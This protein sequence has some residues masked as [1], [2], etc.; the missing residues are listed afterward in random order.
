MKNKLIIHPFLF[1]IFPVLSLFARNLEEVPL[2]TIYLPLFFML[3]FGGV[4]LAA[5]RFIL[6]DIN[7]AGI[8]TSVFIIL[9]FSYGHVLSFV[10]VYLSGMHAHLQHLMLL[11]TWCVVLSLILFFV[12]RTKASLQKYTSFLNLVARV[13]IVLVLFNIMVGWLGLTPG[14]SRIERKI[15]ATVNMKSD[16]VPNIYYII[17]DRYASASTL[18]EAYHYDNS[19]FI[20]SLKRRGFY[21]A[22]QSV[23]NYQITWLSLA[24]SLNLV[25]FDEE[26]GIDKVSGLK[27]LE[28]HKVGQ[29]LKA[30]GYKFIHIGSG[31]NPLSHNRNADVNINYY[32]P[33]EFTMHIYENSMFYPVFSV[34]FEFDRRAQKHKRVLYKFDKFADL[35]QQQG[36][37]FVFAHF[38]L[39]HQP[40]SFD[41]DGN[42]IDRATEVSWGREK[43]YREQLIYTNGMIEKMVDD[44]LAGSKQPPIIVIQADEGP[45][46]LSQPL[47]DYDWNKMSDLELAQKMRILNAY[48]LPGFD[49]D[50]LYPSVSPVNSFR[51]IFNYY[52]GQNY[53]ILSDRS[54]LRKNGRFIDVTTKVKFN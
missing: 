26:K 50:E 28:D 9:A 31:W 7:K 54:Y 3:S 11:L 19:H 13:L 48:Y 21:V 20:D 51:F 4:V 43:A 46:S 23:A 27:M 45:Y 41:K 14:T 1:A 30:N 29:F 38:Q 8:V 15:E 2:V 47:D 32:F 53:K 34:L 39:P 18:K 52:F 10:K 49:D 44:I 24:S 22:H 33:D 42:F 16:G 40:Y 5:L 25:Y 17:F 12:A 36:P 35:A 37:F 6:K